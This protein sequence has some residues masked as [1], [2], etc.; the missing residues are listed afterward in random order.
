MQKVV[1]CLIALILLLSSGVA[2]CANPKAFPSGYP[3]EDLSASSA[4]HDAVLE[5]FVAADY[6]NTA[7]NFTISAW[8]VK[9][10]N[11]TAVTIHAEGRGKNENGTV[12][13]NKTITRLASLNASTAFIGSYN[14]TGYAQVQTANENV[15]L[16]TQAIGHNTTVFRVYEK[17]SQS[18]SS[19]TV[20]TVT[21]FDEFVVI[22]STTTTP[23]PELPTLTPSPSPTAATTLTP[24]PFPTAPPASFPTET[25]TQVPSETPTEVLSET[26]TETPS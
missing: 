13:T 19:S 7:R 18:D 4:V 10:I 3:T 25:P 11:G 20:A 2:G 5:K 23:A 15:T 22:S 26:P 8:E 14:L 1:L 12:S 16:Y 6:N 9:W 21:Q 24:T 17:T